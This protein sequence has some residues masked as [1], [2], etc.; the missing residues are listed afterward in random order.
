MKAYLLISAFVFSFFYNSQAQ[1]GTVDSS[2]GING[3]VA[4]NIGQLE[5]GNLKLTLQ[6]DQ[7]IVMASNLTPTLIIVLRYLPDGTP[8]S[9]FGINGKIES[10]DFGFASRVVEQK[11][12]KILVGGGIFKEAGEFPSYKIV[13][14]RFFSNGTIDSSFGENGT[15]ISVLGALQQFVTDMVLQ[16]DGKILIVGSFSESG[17]SSDILVAR[18]M[19]DGSL[20]SSFG[21]E[22]GKTRIL[23]KTSGNTIAL[24]NDGK[25]IIA[26]SDAIAFP[27]ERFM[28]VRY[29]TDG[30]LD[31]SFGGTGI[32]KTDFDLD[33]EY[34]NDILVQPDDKILAL[35][36]AFYRD[37]LSNFLYY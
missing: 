36:I 28:L 3:V 19:P 24:Q 16:E 2:F 15:V 6:K 27:T 10:E 35:G 17:N 25:I 11:D 14:R 4:S 18:Y 21:D 13:F 32:I 22:Q 5:G 34:I 29:Y 30:M 8:D 7:K 12:G 26:G 37:G 31:R 1:P 33:G 9:S 23:R 20:D